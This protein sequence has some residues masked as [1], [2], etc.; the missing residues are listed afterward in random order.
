VKIK[1]ISEF[2][3]QNA[4]FCDEK[5]KICACR[6]VRALKLHCYRI[7]MV[8]K[9]VVFEKNVRETNTRLLLVIYSP[10]LFVLENRA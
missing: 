1:R 3:G 8:G 9:I 7:N 5:Y 10:F 6:K 4:C 2:Q